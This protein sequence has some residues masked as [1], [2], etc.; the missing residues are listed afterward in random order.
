MLNP[1]RV[2]EL[3]DKAKVLMKAKA[4]LVKAKLEIE[5]RKA[6]KKGR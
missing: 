4:E 2:E 6:D 1:P 3:M 5:A